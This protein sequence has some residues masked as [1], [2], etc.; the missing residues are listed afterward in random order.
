MK[1]VLKQLPLAIA[2]WALSCS[3]QAALLNGSFESGLAGWSAIGDAAAIGALGPVAVPDG[4]SQLVLTT[5]SMLFADDPA[6]NF[7]VSGHEPELAGGA[8]EVFAGLAAGALDPDSSSGLQAYEGSAVRQAFAA[9]AGQTLSFRFDFLSNDP[10]AGDFAFVVIDGL[11]F[12]LGD[13]SGAGA[14]AGAWSWQSGY[15]SFS[16]RFASD[17]M[18]LLAFGVVDVGDF[19]AS[20]ALLIDLVQISAVPEADAA[21]LLGTGLG[22]IAWQRRRRRGADKAA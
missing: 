1:N 13:L 19:A 14:S 9:A 15:A 18:H 10:Q 6:G 21:M 17:G 12:R 5:A 4:A 8:L 20:S 3:A 22:L 7:N 11:Q 2:G 16:H